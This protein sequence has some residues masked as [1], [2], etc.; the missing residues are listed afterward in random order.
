MTKARVLL[1]LG[2]LLIGGAYFA[3]Y[4]P[5]RRRL[6]AARTEVEALQEKVSQSEERVR[7]GEVL[8]QLL[9][10]S[11]AVEAQNFGDAATR[12]SSYF[13]RVAAEAAAATDPAVR[14][15]LESV[16]KTRDSVTAALARAEPAVRTTLREQQ[17]A[18]RRALGY[19][20]AE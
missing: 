12:A 11:D 3:G 19:D 14:A 18:I 6:S 5:E 8:G 16:Q 10:V 9:S 2:V 7:L 17:L 15:V 13:D 1:V 20:A 4:W